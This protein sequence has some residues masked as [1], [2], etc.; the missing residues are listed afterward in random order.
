MEPLAVGN[1]LKRAQ[2]EFR[3]ALNT[4][5]ASLGTNS[6]QL[7]V[8]AE[9]RANPGVSSAQ[10]ARLCAL[11]PQSLGEQ[12]IQLQA[13]GLVERVPGAGR[14][15]DHRITP[16]GR[17]LLARGLERARVV[18]KSVLQDFDEAELEALD[19]SFR[20]IARRAAEERVRM[21]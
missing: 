20:L 17:R 19:A 2:H 9:I 4:E 18:H 16:A 15:L 14:R 13:Q 10:L 5:L 12:V 8:L 7:N 21:K 1:A 3:L 11:T 6:S